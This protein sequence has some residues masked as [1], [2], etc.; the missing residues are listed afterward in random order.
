MSFSPFLPYFYPLNHPAIT[1][2]D[3][4]EFIINSFLCRCSDSNIV[5]HLTLFFKR[6]GK[7]MYAKSYVSLD[8]RHDVR[9]N[10]HTE[11]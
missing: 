2:G 5:P 11:G 6:F 7:I 4:W 8:K 1:A 3:Q 10:V 9:Y